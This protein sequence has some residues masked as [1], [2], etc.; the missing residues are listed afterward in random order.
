MGGGVP[1][2]I[3]CP[4]AG[5]EIVLVALQTPP[6]VARKIVLEVAEVRLCPG[7]FEFVRMDVDVRP[8]DVAQSSCMVEMQVS[9]HHDVDIRRL[10]AEPCKMT[11][12]ALLVGHLRHRQRPCT[13]R[14]MAIAQ[15]R[16]GDLAIVAADV[17]QDA[18]VTRL[19][20]IREDGCIDVGAGTAITGRHGLVVS[21]QGGKQRPHSQNLR[22]VLSFLFTRSGGDAYEM[23]SYAASATRVNCS[24]MSRSVFI[25]D[26]S[27]IRASISRLRAMN[28]GDSFMSWLRR[29]GSGTG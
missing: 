18:S 12:N 8:A 14:V 17:V 15:N 9:D 4:H 29:A 7:S 6:V 22:H 26:V 5:R 11:G 2:R 19:E 21:M 25:P 13:R 20:Q 23:A 24:S 3:D 10:Q 27:R 16:G 1:G 28:S